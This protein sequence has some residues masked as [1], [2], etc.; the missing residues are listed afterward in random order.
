VQGF[1]LSSG[2]GR[3]PNIEKFLGVE[4]VSRNFL[5]LGGDSCKT[6]YSWGHKPYSKVATHLARFFSKEHIRL[7]DA[8]KGGIASIHLS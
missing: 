3:I 2:I 7:E 6:I 8:A 1:T 4:R 5:L